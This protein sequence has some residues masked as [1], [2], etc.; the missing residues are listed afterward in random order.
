MCYFFFLL[1]ITDSQI[2]Y[3]RILSIVPN[4]LRF[5][6]LGQDGGGFQE[7][8]DE[9]G[10]VYKTLY[11]QTVRNNTDNDWHKDHSYQL[12]SRRLK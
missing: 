7:V 4:K 1:I 10:R 5:R 9:G 11:R 3:R 6:V 2:I 12:V 8:T